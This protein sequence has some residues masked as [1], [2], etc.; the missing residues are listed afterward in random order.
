MWVEFFKM[1]APDCDGEMSTEVEVL[2]DNPTRVTVD[3]VGWCAVLRDNL[4]Y[5]IGSHHRRDDVSISAR[6]NKTLRSGWIVESPPSADASSDMTLGVT[7]TLYASESHVLGSIAVPSGDYEWARLSKSIKSKLVASRLR[8]GLFREAPTD[9]NVRLFFHLELEGKCDGELEA[10]LKMRVL[11]RCGVEI[12]STEASSGI[13][14]HSRVL[15][16]DFSFRKGKLKGARCEFE[17][18][19]FRPVHVLH[20]EAVGSPDEE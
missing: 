1:S 10:C 9:G 15:S 16:G 5:V 4:G 7:A 3:R 18:S 14:P 13:C 17:L 6:K 11:D 20:C 8:L 12:E 2:V 19:L